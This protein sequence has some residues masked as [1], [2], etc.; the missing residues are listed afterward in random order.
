MAKQMLCP[1]CGTQ[2]WPKRKTQGSFLVELL[3]WL[4]FIIPGLIYSIWRLTTRSKVCPQCGAPNMIPLNSPAALQ[5]LN[6]DTPSIIEVES[7]TPLP[8]EDQQFIDTVIEIDEAKSSKWNARGRNYLIAGDFKKAIAAF[9][10]A[11]ESDAANSSTY[12]NRSR[13]YEKIGKKE[14]SVN[15]LREAARHG[16]KTAKGK[17]GY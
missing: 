7:K 16:H 10:K 15:D 5:I 12:F 4:F 1:N 8:S 14:E 17:L 3:L 9:S 13:A 2:G 11:I 6:L